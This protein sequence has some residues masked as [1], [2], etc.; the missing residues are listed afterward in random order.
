MWIVMG[1]CTLLGLAGI[2]LVIDALK[3]GG[4]R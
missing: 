1:I 3:N 2:V 4:A